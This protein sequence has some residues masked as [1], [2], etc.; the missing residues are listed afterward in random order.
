MVGYGVLDKSNY[1]KLK[2]SM[3]SGWGATGYLYILNDGKDG[4]GMCG[5]MSNLYYPE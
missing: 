1:W 2:N 5:V 3:G 4:A